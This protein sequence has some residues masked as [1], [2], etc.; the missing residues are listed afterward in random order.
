MLLVLFCVV[1]ILAGVLLLLNLLFAAHKPYTEKVSAYESGFDAIH[2]QTRGVFAISFYTVA[3]LF[4]LFDLEIVLLFPMAVSLY[5]I[6]T[7]G[8]IIGMVFFVL[9]TIGFIVELNSG[10]ISAS[11]KVQK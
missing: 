8:F 4:V 3:L 5:K 1:P 2:N 10:A 7:F 11:N 9:L 6:S